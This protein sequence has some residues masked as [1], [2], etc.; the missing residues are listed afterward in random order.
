MSVC[1]FWG[2]VRFDKFY[3]T[4]RTDKCR[5]VWPCAYCTRPC[6]PKQC[7]RFGRWCCPSA[8]AS[9]ESRSSGDCTTFGTLRKRNAPRR[10][11]LFDP[12][13]FSE[14]S[15]EWWEWRMDHLQLISSGRLMMRNW[16]D[17]RLALHREIAHFMIYCACY[18]W[19]IVN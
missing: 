12:T 6:S 5:S 4:N 19:G 10:S 14:A 2:T 7:C 15:K 17:F 18:N 16:K 9:A 13:I 3:C 11:R 1:V 8:T